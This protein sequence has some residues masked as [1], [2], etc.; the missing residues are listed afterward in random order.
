MTTHT[1]DIMKINCFVKVWLK[2]IYTGMTDSSL[3]RLI[4]VGDI[5]VSDSSFNVFIVF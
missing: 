2:L 4:F 3:E 5:F 1:Y